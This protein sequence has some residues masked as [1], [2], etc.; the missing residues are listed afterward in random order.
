MTTK[1]MSANEI[2]K[3]F[4]KNSFVEVYD[5]CTGKQRYEGKFSRLP[6]EILDTGIKNYSIIS[7]KGNVRFILE[8]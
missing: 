5:E 4:D 6:K 7:E 8:V 1:T 3:M 2:I